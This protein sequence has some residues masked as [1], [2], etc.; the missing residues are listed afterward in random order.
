MMG[1]SVFYS[2]RIQFII[3]KILMSQCRRTRA[4][5]YLL[6]FCSSNFLP[7]SQSV[8]ESL[9]HFFLLFICVIGKQRIFP[10]IYVFGILVLYI[11]L[12]FSFSFPLGTILPYSGWNV[13]RNNDC[14][15]ILSATTVCVFNEIQR[16]KSGPKENT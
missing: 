16:R 12:I 3:G 2:L 5:S 7:S 9:L 4:Y 1:F 14:Y 11:F 15:S 10:Q 13:V 6:Y 8:I